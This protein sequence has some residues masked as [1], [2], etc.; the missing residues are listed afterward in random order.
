VE[1]RGKGLGPAVPGL[2]I[3]QAEFANGHALEVVPALPGLDQDDL[4]LG[5][6]DGDGETGKASS[7][8]HVD[9][10]AHASRERGVEGNRVENEVP[11]HRLGRVMGGEV[12]ARSPLCDKTCEFGQGFADGARMP[13]PWR[14]S[15]EAFDQKP[16]QFGL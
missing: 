8:A 2:D 15:L 13:A 3:R 1:G 6:E 14:E 7:R 9:Q 16:D 10:G 12:H 11:H 5:V 4:S